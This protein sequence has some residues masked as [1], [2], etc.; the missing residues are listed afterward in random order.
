MEESGV[1]RQVTAV[2]VQLTE[3]ACHSERRRRRAPSEAEGK[4]LGLR[5]SE[6]WRSKG[7][8]RFNTEISHP[9]G[10][11]MTARDDRG[12][13]GHC[14]VLRQQQKKSRKPRSWG[15]G[16]VFSSLYVLMFSY[17]LSYVLLLVCLSAER[18]GLCAK[19]KQVSGGD[20]L[21]HGFRPQYHRRWRT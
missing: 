21:S 8:N 10:F 11:E 12:F 18:C 17:R 19:K 16:P 1:I 14:F 20:L 13:F 4:N 6:E 5:L 15:S 2:S 7:G 9:S 3:K